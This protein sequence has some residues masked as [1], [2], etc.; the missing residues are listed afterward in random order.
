M[1]LACRHR[2]VEVSE[3]RVRGGAVVIDAAVD[4]DGGLGTFTLVT[5][6]N[7]T[8]ETEAE[9]V[10]NSVSLGPSSDMHDALD[11]ELLGLSVYLNRPDPVLVAT[12]NWLAT[13][14]FLGLT[15]A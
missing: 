11:A 6:D 2:G 5:S 14:W 9:I 3:S 10:V 7:F 15:W 8:Q 13:H 1:R 12:R 4:G